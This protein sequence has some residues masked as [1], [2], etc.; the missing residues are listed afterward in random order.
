MDGQVDAD[1]TEGNYDALVPQDRYYELLLKRFYDFQGTLAKACQDFDATRSEISV[2][3]ATPRTQ[4]AWCDMFE[5]QP[6][7]LDLLGS[8]DEAAIYGGLQS[9]ASSMNIATSIS[10]KQSYWAW[11]LLALVPD[12]GTL[13]YEKLGRIREIGQSAGLAAARLRNG[14]GQG[15]CAGNDGHPRANGTGIVDTE[16]DIS[17][18]EM[19]ISG[20]EGEVLDDTEGS[21]LARAQAEIRTQ[22]GDRLVHP[23]LFS[24]QRA[25]NS[26]RPTAADHGARGGNGSKGRTQRACSPILP[27]QPSSIQEKSAKESSHHQGQRGGSAGGV[28]DLNTS[29]TIDMI[30][31][32]VAECFGQKDLLAYRRRW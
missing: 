10:P 24:P 14:N 13:N 6:P 7:N 3:T 27:S 23:P 9:C 1:V 19:S 26:R 20:D 30:L 2:T 11:S 25:T 15:L 21:D 8:L 4:R 17:D 29:V 22:L 16:A 32:I 31:T 18:A 12:V 5:R 28:T